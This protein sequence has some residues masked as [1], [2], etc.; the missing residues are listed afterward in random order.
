MKICNSRRIPS[1]PAAFTLVELLVVIAIVVILAGLLLPATARAMERARIAKCVQNLQQIGLAFQLYMSDHNDRFPPHGRLP[2]WISFQVGGGD[3]SPTYWPASTA[4]PAE[5][6]PLWRYAPA[7]EVFRC[8][9]DA[10]LDAVPD[11]P[12]AKNL[13]VSVGTSYQYNVYPWSH[14]YRVTP[15]DP[16]KGVT[17]K[18]VAWVPDPSRYILMHE[19]SAMP[20]KQNGPSDPGTW[21]VWH[22][23]RG[24]GSVH[25]P[26]QI[27]SKVVSPVLFVDGHAAAHDFTKA[28]KSK[29]SAE[30]TADW[31]WYK[32]LR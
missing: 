14:E 10:G 16:F 24:P 25:S 28:V 20:Y 2:N 27:K 12:R 13:F 30:A 22:Y 23:R 15:S 9:A 7:A 11:W 17:E 8:A 4:L 18:P 5:G 26:A 19:P 29:W 21:A 6:R 3:P 31:I 1:R 32:P